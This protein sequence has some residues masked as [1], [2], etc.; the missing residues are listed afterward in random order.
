MDTAAANAFAT[1]RDPQHAVVAVTTGIVNLLDREELEGVLAHEL[2][3][4]TNR[5]ILISSVAATVAGAISMIAQMMQW[6]LM[7]AGFGGRDDRDREGGG[8]VESLALMILA[9]IAATVIQLA[10]SR[11][12]EFGADATGAHLKGNAE[13][14]ARALEKLE[15]ASHQI[16]MDVSPAASHLFIVNPLHGFSMAGLFST[17][18]STADRVQRLRSM[19]IDRANQFYH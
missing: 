18:P 16:P 15:A 13:P 14:L 8:I 3:H 4:V 1:G 2:G 9:P 7:F 6:T 11:S 12:R 10:I 17:H 19:H 5:D